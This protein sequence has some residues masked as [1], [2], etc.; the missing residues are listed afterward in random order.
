[1][2]SNTDDAQFIKN[3]YD[4]ATLD[5]LMA[6]NQNIRALIK[7]NPDF[8]HIEINHF[9]RQPIKPGS[10][11][12]HIRVDVSRNGVKRFFFLSEDF[13]TRLEESSE[14]R[15][16]LHTVMKQITAALESK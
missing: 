2:M 3:V 11:Q 9:E 8:H 1:M 15:K 12:S 10:S 13:I 14:I 4:E 5:T 16:E 6:L 7:H